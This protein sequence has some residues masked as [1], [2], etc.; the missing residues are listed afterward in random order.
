MLKVLLLLGRYV[1]IILMYL[2]YFYEGTVELLSTENLGEL[3]F[4]KQLGNIYVE[5]QLITLRN[6]NTI[7]HLLPIFF[8]LQFNIHFLNCI[9]YYKDKKVG[10]FLSELTSACRYSDSL[11]SIHSTSCKS[12]LLEKKPVIS[13][14]LLWGSLFKTN[15]IDISWYTDITAIENRQMINH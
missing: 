5:K 10:F 4:C 11:L 12:L 8:T 14:L 3:M 6:I 9:N 15:T 1:Y 2:L 13:M 7:L